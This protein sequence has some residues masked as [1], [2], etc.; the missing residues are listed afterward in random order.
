MATTSF[1]AH[2]YELYLIQKR[3]K[4]RGSTMNCFDAHSY[5]LYLISLI[6]PI[7]KFFEQLSFDAHSYEL[8]LI[9]KRNRLIQK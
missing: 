7:M 5:E 9:F 2:S 6:L 8:Y 3:N 4:T 1:D